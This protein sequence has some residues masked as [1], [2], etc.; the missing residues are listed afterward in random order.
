MT[1]VKVVVTGG[2]GFVGKTVCRVL[3]RESH[4]VV[5]L[6]RGP[7]R[8]KTG[9][10][11]GVETRGWPDEQEL[12]RLIGKT[13]AVLNLAGEPIAQRWS[14]AVRARLEES[15][16]GTLGR[17]RRA[18]EKAERPPAVLVSASAI[19]FYGPCD[20]AE[21]A[22][23]ARKGT[24]FLPDLCAA[25][26]A[27]ARDFEALGTRTVQARIGMVL[28]RDG[29][30]LAKMLPPFRLG[31]GG[32]IGSGSQWMSWIHRDDLARLLVAA[33]MDE[34]FSGPLNGTA[35]EPV[36]NAGFTSSL[37]RALHRPAV[38][39]LPAALLKILFGEMASILVEGQRVIPKKATQL[40]F[41]FQFPELDLALKDLL[42]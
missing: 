41:A 4:Q 26:E 10:P 23:D 1:L 22:E 38:F 28:A 2:T 37:G 15:R 7:A 6:T 24:G 21:L 27:A 39:P 35:P 20:D 30:A 3:S 19:G 33:L 14:A 11:A 16:I 40:G 12:A 8:A 18:A 31:L 5:V 13:D 9:L 34:R 29:G 32:V 25:W 17:L 36:T 42:G